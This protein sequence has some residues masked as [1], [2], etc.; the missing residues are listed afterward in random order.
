MKASSLLLLQ[1]PKFLLTGIVSILLPSSAYSGE[2]WEN[3]PAAI[4]VLGQPD[5]NSG[6]INRGLGAS[7]TAADALYFPE[8]IAIDPTTGKI[9]VLDT[10]NSR[11]LRFASAT[12]LKDGDPPE[13]V[14]AQSNY[15]DTAGNL[16]RS[17]ILRPTSLTIDSAGTMWVADYTNHR[18]LRFDNAS[19]KSSG[20]NADGVLGAPDYTTLN[21]ETTQTGMKFPNGVAVDGAGNLFVS[22]SGN[23]RILRF[24]NAALKA[25]GAA[26]D[27]VFGQVDFETGTTGTS[28][29]ALDSPEKCW[30][31]NEG[32]LWVTERFNHR[33]IG[34]QNP[35]AKSTGAAADRVLGQAGFLT[36]A[37]GTSTS[38]V[39][40]PAGGF[41]DEEGTLWLS[42]SAN[43]RI[44][45]FDD[46][47]NKGDGAPA[48]GVIGQPDFTSNP[49]VT[50]QSG[51]YTPNASVYAEGLLVVLDT[52]NSRILV[53]EKDR[54]QPDNLVGSKAGN[55]RGNNLYN[56]N[57]SGQTATI[58]M[59][60]KRPGKAFF[61]VQN[62]GNVM[63][64]Y[65][66]RS[67]R[68]NSKLKVKYIQTPG[69]N[70]TA[71]ITRGQLALGGVAASGSVRLKTT[72][73]S[74][75]RS[76]GKKASR[77]LTFK[78]TSDE[79]GESDTVKAKVKKLK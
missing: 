66:V 26:A 60:G 31:D 34:Y 78:T 36:S 16:T 30:F 49:F 46:L 2:K 11:I 45:R 38:A 32:T 69:G 18:V 5:Y 50:T 23:D 1:F 25:N 19:T 35:S 14:I 9:F 13:A 15:T 65:L 27:A 28:A 22:E 43:N 67:T 6:S 48:D 61:S 4:T 55:Q 62:D 21:P 41:V 3:G 59:K 73:T 7:L 52:Q 76:L 58:K 29:T 71:A 53:F 75:K 57:G 74:T 72:I 17:R 54:Y 64:G 44:L 51:M 37:N 63:D 42:D 8:D 68:G 70:V 24:N 47:E 79:D 12:A 33:V 39:S 56:G 10:W 77:T 20:A 40:N